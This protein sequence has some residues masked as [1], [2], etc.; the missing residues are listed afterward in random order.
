MKCIYCFRRQKYCESISDG[1][2]TWTK[3]YETFNLSKIRSLD[4]EDSRNALE[5]FAAGLQ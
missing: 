4:D 1:I 2:S 3:C 5:W